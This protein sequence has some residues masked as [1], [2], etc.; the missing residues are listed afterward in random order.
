[1][2]SA[3]TCLLGLP[4]LVWVIL[5]IREERS[6]HFKAEVLFIPDAVSP[7]L[8]DPYLVV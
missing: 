8:N 7:S 2:R 6:E 4:G 3:Y 1:M 5:G